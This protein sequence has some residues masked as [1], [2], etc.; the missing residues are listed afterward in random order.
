MRKTLIILGCIVIFFT[1]PAAAQILSPVAHLEGT[2]D[3]DTK[4]FFVGK[5][6]ISGIFQGY[7]MDSFQDNPLFKEV[8]IFPLFGSSTFNDIDSV[9]IIDTQIT[10]IE[11]LEDITD[12]EENNVTQ[13][14]NVHIFAEEGPFLLAANQ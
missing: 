14:S 10:D 3:A 2:L 9:T 5:T 4:A 1:L 6:S 8:N 7:Q 12:L 13:F 11:L